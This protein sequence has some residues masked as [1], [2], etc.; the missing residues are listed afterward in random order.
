MIKT[1][2]A[3]RVI[4]TVFLMVLVSCSTGN[5]H[6]PPSPGEALPSLSAVTN[7]T[8]PGHIVDSSGRQVLLRG[9]NVNSHIEYW[10]YDPDI[11]T[12]YPFTEEDADLL[13]SMGWNLVRLAISWSRVEPK[14]GEYDDAYLDEV[15]KSVD[16]LRRRG[17]YTLI[18]LHQDAWGASLAAPPGTICDEG[19]PAGGWDGAPAWAT[20]DDGEPRCSNGPR[21]LVPAVRAAWV[22]FFNNREGPG[23]VG[24]RTRYV[25]MFAYLVKHLAHD[26]SVAGYDV[27]NEPNQLLEETH[28]ALSQLY[29][30][31]LKAMRQAEEE[32]GAPRRLFFFEPSIA[33]HAVGFP[34]PAPFEHD[35]QVV[36]SP[37]LYQEG[38]NEGTL[39]E[40]FARASKETVELYKGAP[41][42]TS[43]WGGDPN[44]A[45]DPEDDYFQRH[46]YEQ[47]NYLFGATMWTWHTSCGDPHAYHAARDGRAA[48]VWGV[49]N[50]NCEDNSFDGLRTE[51]V[52]VLR[53]MTVRFAPGTID[54]VEWSK[55]DSELSARGNDAPTGN[56][57]EVFVPYSDPASLQIESSGLGKIQSTPWFGGTLFYAPADGGAWSINIKALS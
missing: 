26:P 9:V 38:I 13:A 25:H 48:T 57:L 21:E 17:I 7:G 39:E 35:D 11:P 42:L 22:N 33:W 44:R 18:D 12:T 23:G 16:M 53:K 56:L 1:P 34:P 49:F 10:Q 51:Y 37:P 29:E 36:Y 52:D 55:D 47:D 24:I 46:L 20:F 27:M 5:K 54:R 32:L 28:T 19:R 31:A 14:P 8:E 45:K 15:A 4:I 50:Q 41:V 2:T 43:E 6:R 40:A 3:W 30:D